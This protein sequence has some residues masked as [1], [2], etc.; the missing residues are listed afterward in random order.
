ML[1][2]ITLISTFM[3]LVVCLIGGISLAASVTMGGVPEVLTEEVDE[4][5]I[6]S[7]IGELGGILDAFNRNPGYNYELY[8]SNATIYATVTDIFSTDRYYMAFNNCTC[9]SYS[10]NTSYCR[11]HCVYFAI[12]HYAPDNSTVVHLDEGQDLREAFD[13]I[14][15]EGLSG[16]TIAT[17][18]FQIH[19]KQNGTI[20]YLEGNLT[21]EEVLTLLEGLDD[22][23]AL[24]LLHEDDSFTI[25][26]KA[27]ENPVVNRKNNEEKLD[28]E[29]EEP[30]L[31]DLEKTGS[32]GILVILYIAVGALI[33]I[34]GVVLYKIKKR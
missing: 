8:A 20:I 15:G 16:I 2:K 34:A 7:T 6:T 32:N 22:I 30:V 4:I 24:V 31:P 14:I 25:T 27:G 3:I 21:E 9:W 29:P 17:P 18:S 1:K 11:S 33:V 5:Y 26:L 23:D 28:D 13:L 10:K 12:Y 19:L